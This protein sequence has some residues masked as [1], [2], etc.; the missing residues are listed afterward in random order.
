MTPAVLVA[1]KDRNP[2]LANL[3]FTIPA[4]LVGVV[5]VAA[6]VFYP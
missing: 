4:A 6:A 1:C 5:S 2:K 3:G